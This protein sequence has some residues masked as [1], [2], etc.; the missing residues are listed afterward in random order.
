MSDKFEIIEPGTLCELPS[1][2]RPMIRDET[3]VLCGSVH[4]LDIPQDAD[5]I[6]DMQVP[7]QLIVIR[8][9]RR[10]IWPYGGVL[11]LSELGPVWVKWWFMV[12]IRKVLTP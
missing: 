9:T 6:W 11:F 10:P 3:G 4:D 5:W 12:H 2:A 1:Y 7:S 8:D